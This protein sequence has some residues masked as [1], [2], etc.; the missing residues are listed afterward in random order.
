MI[1]NNFGRRP[2]KGITRLERVCHNYRDIY[3]HPHVIKHTRDN[4]DKTQISSWENAEQK[5][6]IGTSE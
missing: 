6:L 1:Q 2:A 4:S 5:H 3:M